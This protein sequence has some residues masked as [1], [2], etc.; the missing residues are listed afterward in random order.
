M[1]PSVPL[2]LQKNIL[3]ETVANMPKL[4]GSTLIILENC[5]W[6]LNYGQEE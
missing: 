5:H 6:S 4:H 2:Q 1:S 3:V